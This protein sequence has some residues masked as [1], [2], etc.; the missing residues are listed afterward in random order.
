MLLLTHA[1][2]DAALETLAGWTCDG[3][4]IVKVF[5]FPGP[6]D[7]VAFAGRL[8]TRAEA[9]A[10]HPDVVVNDRGV[11]VMWTTHDAGGV[12]EKDVAGAWMT[13]RCV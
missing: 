4:S 8:V 2:I 11:T 7:A 12:T 5:T 9:V 1:E 3:T 10:H 6:P 13:D